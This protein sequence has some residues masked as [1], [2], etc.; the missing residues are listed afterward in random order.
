MAR[1]IVLSAFLGLLSACSTTEQGQVSAG[2]TTGLEPVT[3]TP[4]PTHMGRDNPTATYV[5]PSMGPERRIE[6]PP[7]PRRP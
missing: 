5:Q 7:A 6:P 3:L 2:G 4:S 1:I